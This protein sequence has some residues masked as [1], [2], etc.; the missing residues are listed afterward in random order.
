MK[1]ED[2]RMILD[3]DD[4]DSLRSVHKMVKNINIS[5]R[6]KNNP[7]QFYVKSKLRNDKKD[8]YIYNRNTS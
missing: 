4:I 5:L 7:N 3:S 1:F 8:V 6:E 2:K